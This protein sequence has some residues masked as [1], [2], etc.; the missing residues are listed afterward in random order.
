MNN[1]LSVLKATLKAKITPIWT[2]LKYWTSWSFIKTR[3]ITRI[4]EWFSKILNVKPRDKKDYYRFFGLLVSKRLAHAVLLIACVASLV[5]LA[6]NNPFVNIKNGIGTDEKVY[7]YKSIPLRFAEGSVKIKAKSGYIAYSGNVED[8]YASGQG[9]LYDEE[10][11]TVYY[12]EFSKNMY[13]G[14]GTL[15]YVNGQAKYTGAFVDNLYEGTGTLYRENGTKIY[16]GAFVK[17]LKEGNGSLYDAAEN[18]VFTGSFRADDIVYAQLLNKTAG[19]ISSMY[20]GSQTIFQGSESYVVMMSDIDAFYSAPNESN[21]ITDEMIPDR[22]Y[23]TKSE[24]AYGSKIYTTLSD[25]KSD[26]GSPLFEGNSYAN[27]AEIV[28]IDQLKKQ[29]KEFTLDVNC[30]YEQIYDE[31]LN[32]TEYTT[33]AL[34]YL[35]VYE[36]DGITYTFVTQDRGDAFFMYVL[37]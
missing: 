15:Y 11:R 14:S 17:G 5:Y 30:M 28:G 32:V 37:E 24:F 21:S 10:G 23:V 26:F 36:I 7:S 33:D 20:T 34:V 2:K 9:E 6:Y 25:I 4:R 18:L 29:G 31:V 1:L 12:G 19:E 3:I 8:G 16:N 22:V 27:L 35:Y 13:N